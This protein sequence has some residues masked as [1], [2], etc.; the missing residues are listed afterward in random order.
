MSPQKVRLG[1]IHN[2]TEE[3]EAVGGLSEH[4]L[5][6]KSVLCRGLG[7]HSIAPSRAVGRKKTFCYQ[8][9]V[10]S[11]LCFQWTRV[12]LLWTVGKGG[13]DEVVLTCRGLIICTCPDS[14]Q[15]KLSQSGALIRKYTG[16]DKKKKKYPKFKSIHDTANM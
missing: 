7:V 14:A 10:V 2:A 6:T 1:Y 13:V 11:V 8:P 16:N 5:H 15:N 4:F 12:L 3:E 9:G